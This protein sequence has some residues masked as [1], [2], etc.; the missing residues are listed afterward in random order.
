MTTTQITKPRTHLRALKRRIAIRGL[1]VV[2]RR[3]AG[4][5]ALFAWRDELLS[6]IGGEADASPQKKA[7]VEM[8]TRTK[9]YVDHLDS[10]LMELS[11]LVN[12]RK[13]TVWPVLRERQQLCDSLAKMLVQ[14]GLERQAKK[15]PTLQ[16]YLLT[17][18]KESASDETIVVE[19]EKSDDET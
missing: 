6:A 16:E 12:R 18:E 15:V 13:K 11:T 5:K 19:P 7:L 14:L 4:A 9:L 1:S 3:W 2:D 8:C 17:K 10:Y